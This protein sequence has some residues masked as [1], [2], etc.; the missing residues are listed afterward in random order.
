MLQLLSII[1]MHNVLF[2]G[3]DYN[4]LAGKASGGVTIKATAVVLSGSQYCYEECCSSTESV[5]QR[6]GWVIKA[7]LQLSQTL[8][9]YGQI[10]LNTFMIKQKKKKITKNIKTGFKKFI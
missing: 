10:L 5:T 4:S 3:L 7:E 1:S 9:S 8:T 6:A 2:V